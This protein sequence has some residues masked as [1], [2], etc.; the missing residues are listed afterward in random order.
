M[1]NWNGFSFMLITLYLSETL[2]CYMVPAADLESSSIESAELI[3]SFTGKIIY[4]NKVEE[5][6]AMVSVASAETSSPFQTSSRAPSPKYA[7][8]AVTPTRAAASDSPHSLPTPHK[9]THLV[10]RKYADVNII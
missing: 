2:T 4:F 7:A 10:D 3:L 5:S 9:Q 6:P 1:C 8:P